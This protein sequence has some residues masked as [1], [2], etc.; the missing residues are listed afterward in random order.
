MK[1][2][3]SLIF[4]SVLA[5]SQSNQFQQINSSNIGALMSIS[6]ENSIIVSENV[7]S[8]IGNYNIAKI[9]LI[10]DKVN[11]QQNGNRNELYYRDNNGLQSSSI[12]I[13]ENGINNYIDVNGS[14]SI[15]D[16]MTIKIT[17]DNRTVI[18]RNY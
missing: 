17:G 2:F 4:F 7:L 10:D 1:I 11:L 8:Q 3:I 5:K 13:I 6:G 15:S 18:V 9:N 12:N 14:N 16:G